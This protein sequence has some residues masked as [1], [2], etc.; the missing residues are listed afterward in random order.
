MVFFINKILLGVLEACYYT[1]SSPLWLKTF[2]EFDGCRLVKAENGRNFVFQRKNKKD[3][4]SPF[5]RTDRARVVVPTLTHAVERWNCSSGKIKRF[6]FFSSNQILREVPYIE[7][8]EVVNPRKKR[9]HLYIGMH[10]Y[11]NTLSLYATMCYVWGS[12]FRPFEP[13]QYYDMF[14]LL[15][16]CFVRAF[17]GPDDY[18][19][20]YGQPTRPVMFDSLQTQLD[21]TREIPNTSWPDPIRSDP[22][23]EF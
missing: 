11:V 10:L 8:L 17:H 23:R 20:R 7:L 19:R 22:T 16:F 21:S 12:S 14:I 1:R 4:A 3:N 6:L 5:R 9:W 2:S 13:I 18:S 15:P